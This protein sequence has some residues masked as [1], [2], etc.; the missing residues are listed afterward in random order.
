[1]ADEF[2]GVFGDD[3][4]VEFADEHQD[5]CACPVAADADVVQS[6]VVAQGEFAVAVDAVCADAEV[7]AD[8]DALPGG[9]GSGSCVPGKRGRSERRMIPVPAPLTRFGAGSILGRT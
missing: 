2:A 9:D 4:D 6:A 5:V 3:A 8:V 7:F 1:L